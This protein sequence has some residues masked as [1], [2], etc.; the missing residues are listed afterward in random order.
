MTSSQIDMENLLKNIYDDKTSM[1]KEKLQITQELEKVTLL[2][3]SLEKEKQSFEEQ[4]QELIQ[5]AKIQARNILLEAKEDVNEMIKKINSLASSKEL[6]NT[7]NRLNAKINEIHLATNEMNTKPTCEKNLNPNDIK[8]NT[9]VFITNLKQNG[10]VLSHVSKS[11]EVQVQVGSLKINVPIA[12]LKPCQ[13]KHTSSLTANKNNIPSFSKS[14]IINSEINVIGMNVEESIF[15]IDKFLDDASLAKLQT[16]RIVH[17]KGTGKLRNG[18]HQFLKK[19]SHVKSFRLG[20]YGEGEMGV[21]VVEL[22]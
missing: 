2:R 15:M 4:R 20:T 14:K 10:R 17:G 16:I 11:H 21:T 13:K 18:I 7:R 8:P 1:E 12:Y 3:C 22:K 19:H 5:N 6:E 9:E